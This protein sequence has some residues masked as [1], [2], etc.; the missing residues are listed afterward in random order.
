MVR[1]SRGY[2]VELR[3]IVDCSEDAVD[4]KDWLKV[5]YCGP[6]KAN[7]R[8][9]GVVAG[10]NCYRPDPESYATSIETGAT[11]KGSKSHFG[12]VMEG[13]AWWWGDAPTTRNTKISGVLSR[14]LVPLLPPPQRSPTSTPAPPKPTTEHNAVAATDPQGSGDPPDRCHRRL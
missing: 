13:L 8:T 3:V 1:S 4:E 7:T 9:C 11:V 5:N 2:V 6:G 14:D 12:V 10:D